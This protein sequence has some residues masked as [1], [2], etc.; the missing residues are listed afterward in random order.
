[1]AIAQLTQLRISIPASGAPP[2]LVPA[3]C[4]PGG[5]P[6]QDLPSSRLVSFAKDVTVLGDAPP[7]ASS[8]EGGTQ[9]LLGSAVAEDDVI[10]TMGDTIDCVGDV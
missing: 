8:L 5:V 4:H 1:M 9:A 10:E 7:P 2:G 3:D 6:S